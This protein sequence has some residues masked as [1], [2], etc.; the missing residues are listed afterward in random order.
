VHPDLIA[1]EQDGGERDP[2]NQADIR[3]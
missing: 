2:Q 3:H 1:V